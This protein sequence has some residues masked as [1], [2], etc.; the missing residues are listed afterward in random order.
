[1]EKA[2]ILKA[3]LIFLF[4]FPDPQDFSSIAVII[5]LLKRVV[6]PVHCGAGP[7]LSQEINPWGAGGGARGGGAR[8]SRAW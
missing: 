7:V 1:M 2:G 4:S 3:C 8:E 5:P 6:G